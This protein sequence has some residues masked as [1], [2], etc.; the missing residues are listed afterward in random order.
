MHKI[1]K[2]YIHT[3]YPTTNIH[4]EHYHVVD[5]RDDDATVV[6]SNRANTRHQTAH[7]EGGKKQPPPQVL[8]S[9][10]VNGYCNHQ[11]GISEGEIPPQGQEHMPC[12]NSKHF[13][14]ADSGTTGHF[15]VPGANV[16]DIHPTTHPINITCPNGSVKN[17]YIRA[18]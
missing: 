12:N 3:S 18:T 1:K 10:G 5:D 2:S 14:I 7:S 11:P 13:A 17:Q 6:T 8:N 15:C 16:T 4:T 9:E